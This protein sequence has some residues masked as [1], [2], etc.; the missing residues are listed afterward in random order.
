MRDSGTYVGFEVVQ[1]CFADSVTL[2]NDRDYVTL[3]IQGFH[4]YKIKRADPE[5]EL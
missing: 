1:L 3:L 2:C 4:C 5:K